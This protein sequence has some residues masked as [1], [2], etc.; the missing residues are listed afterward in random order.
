MEKE[1][2]KKKLGQK[3][4]SVGKGE[5]RRE[6]HSFSVGEHQAQLGGLTLSLLGNSQPFIWNAR[7]EQ[8]PSMG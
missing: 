8:S 6:T 1:I 5:G 7:P 2:V 4:G 3:L